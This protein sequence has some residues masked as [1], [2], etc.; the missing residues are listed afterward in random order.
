M[1]TD[2]PRG[3]VCMIASM[4]LFVSNDA[5][6]KFASQNIPL[7]QAIFIRGVLVTA[8]LIAV[9]AGQ[10]H[11]SQWRKLAQRDVLGRS[12]CDVVG[13]YGYL[14][15]LTHIPLPI[16]LAIS[17]AS[18]LLVVPL[19]VLLL[20][21]KI[22]WRRWAALVVGF[23][24]VLMVLQP[25]PQ[26][27]DVWALV[28]LASTAV[29]ACRD[30]ITR[31]IPPAIPSILVTALS[32]AVLAVASSGL[33]FY[34]GLRPVNTPVLLSVTAAALMLGGGMYLLVVSTRIGE[35]SVVS[36]F[37]Y[38]AMVWGIALGYAIWGD[39][40]GTAAWCGIALI[41]GAGLYAA[42]RERLRRSGAGRG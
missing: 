9:A 1:H 37:R 30:V 34:E 38:T 3:I 7:P 35:V 11:L 40:P 21:E 20:D 12:A 23:A 10:G 4:A 22:G 24:G 8:M 13:A 17:M 39:L 32:A 2:N 31:R 27:V 25:G 42:H 5:L 15:A 16:V 28:A 26:G 29:H 14:L 33:V 18:P 19:A 41:V 36:G 6:M